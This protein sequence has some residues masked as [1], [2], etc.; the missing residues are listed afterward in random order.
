MRTIL[1]QLPQG[2]DPPII[3]KLALDSAPSSTIAVS[4]SRDL[5]E[6]TEIARKRIRRTWRASPESGAVALVGGRPRAVNVVI[7]PDKLM[8]YDRLT[9]EDVRQALI[10][11]EPGATGRGGLNRGQS[12]LV[13]RTVG[14]VERPEDFSTLIVGKPQRPA[15]PD[16]RRRPRRGRRGRA[17]GLSRLWIADSRLTSRGGARTSPQTRSP[18]VVQSAFRTGSKRREPDRPETVRQ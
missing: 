16:R 18:G 13:L 2:T 15:N 11:G 10:R 8:K 7:E 9:V 3:D 1:S 4:G 12:E 17:P 5:R 14:R 6:V